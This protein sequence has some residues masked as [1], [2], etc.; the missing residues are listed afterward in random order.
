M[1]KNEYNRDRRLK[2]KLNEMNPAL[3]HLCAHIG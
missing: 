2:G 3:G 1:E